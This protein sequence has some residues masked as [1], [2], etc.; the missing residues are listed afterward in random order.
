MTYKLI[1]GFKITE[2]F[3]LESYNRGVR[4][5]LIYTRKNEYYVQYQYANKNTSELFRIDTKYAS[6]M[7]SHLQAQVIQIMNEVVRQGGD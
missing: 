2:R 7:I 4:D 5:M 3:D 6:A 1:L